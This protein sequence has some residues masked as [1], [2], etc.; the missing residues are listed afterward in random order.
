MRT[1]LY[2]TRFKENMAISTPYLLNIGNLRYNLTFALFLRCK[3]ITRRFQKIIKLA[4]RVALETLL[5]VLYIES[6]TY[7]VRNDYPLHNIYRICLFYLVR[8]YSVL[9]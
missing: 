1:V 8:T 4:I 6:Q 3:K 9:R 5:K 2:D 7:C